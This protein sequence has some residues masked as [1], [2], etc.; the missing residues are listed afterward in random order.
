MCI[1]SQMP[2]FST[3][4]LCIHGCGDKQLHLATL[5][6]ANSALQFCNPFY[7]NGTIYDV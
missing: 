7:L 5:A 3:V 1:F 6:V 2:Y 4:A